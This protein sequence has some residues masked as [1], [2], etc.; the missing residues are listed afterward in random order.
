MVSYHSNNCLQKQLS[1]TNPKRS[2]HFSRVYQNLHYS[3]S[4][5]YIVKIIFV[6]K[7]NKCTALKPPLHLLVCH[8]MPV[9]GQVLLYF[10]LVLVGSLGHLPHRPFFSGLLH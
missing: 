4:T 10:S 2:I 6:R 1:F 3:I 8:L 9:S 7:S 5:S